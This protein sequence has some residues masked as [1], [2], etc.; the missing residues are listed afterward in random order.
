MQEYIAFDSHKHYTLM[1]REAVASGRVV[2]R[3]IEHRPGAIREALAG[4]EPG[5]EVAVEAM[6]SWYWIIDEIEQAGL[7]PK[8]VHPRKA[9]LMMGMINKTDRLDVHGLNRLQRNGTLPTV[10]IAPPDVRDLREVTRT[11]M[12]LTQHRTRLKN[13]LLATITKY[14]L[15]V[16]GCSDPF[17]VKARAQWTTLLSR[18]PVQTRWC[19]E[20][21]W[22]QLELVNSQVDQQEKRLEDLME[23]TPA[24][25]LL[26]TLPGIGLILAGVAAMEIGDVSRFATAERLASY[27]GTTP[28]VHSSGGKT[29]YGRLRSDVN[30]Y[31]KW[32]FI[33]AAN[34][35]ALHASRKPARHV[36]QLYRRLRQRRNHPKA[37]GAVARHLAA[38]SYWV[39]KKKQAYRDPSLGRANEG[40]SAVAA[41]L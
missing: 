40:V 5:T 31:L 13:R 41:C 14:G 22:Q 29:R 17:G 25:A 6:G 1:E 38:A 28:R 15:S 21:L 30:R 3:R 32:A 36:S 16:D 18:L 26:K 11:R 39:L 34:S 2:Q 9:K 27:A 33:E 35:V 24:I 20:L 8:L 7:V 19:A 10:W 4:C 37:V 23:V 12:V